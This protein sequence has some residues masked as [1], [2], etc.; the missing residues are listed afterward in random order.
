ML[1]NGV[2]NGIFGSRLFMCDFEQSGANEL[3]G[4]RQWPEG[5]GTGLDRLDWTVAAG[6]FQLDTGPQTV[7]FGSY[8]LISQ[9]RLPVTN[10]DIAV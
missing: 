1:C 4:M 8:C 6:S 3:C 2:I 9:Y 10:N 7:L 5:S